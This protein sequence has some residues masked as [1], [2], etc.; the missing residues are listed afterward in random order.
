MC[1]QMYNFVSD[2]VVYVKCVCVHYIMWRAHIHV[3]AQYA[4]VDRMAW[5][6]HKHGV[7]VCMC[8]IY[9][10]VY[11]M[12]AGVHCIVYVCVYLCMYVWYIHMCTSCGAVC[13]V[14]F[15]YVYIYVCMYVW[16]IHMCTSC[17]MVCTVLIMYIYMYD[18]YTRVHRREWCNGYV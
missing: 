17:G 9:T 12:W 4:W 8:G 10:H 7:H 3:C 6:A 16:Y 18:I 5:C 14:L 15:M 11:I 2:Y 13:T 1:L